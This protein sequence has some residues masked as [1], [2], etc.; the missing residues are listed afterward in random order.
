[1]AAGCVLLGLLVTAARLSP[2]PQ[3]LGTHQQ[4]G[5]PPC[6]F[7]VVFDN[8]CP[9]CGM[10]TSWSHMVRGHVVDSLRANVGG[11]LLAVMALVAAPLLLA[12]ALR[13]RWIVRPP[14][15][16]AAVAIT[17]SVLVVT[18]IDWTIRML[19]P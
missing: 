6:T 5:L 2:S 4:L 13:G 3:G 1:M 12:S 18:M 9:A 14:G 8:R 15:E 11:A 19:A 17:G 7:R 10:T 16:W